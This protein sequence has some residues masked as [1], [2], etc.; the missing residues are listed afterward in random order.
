MI[1][2]TLKYSWQRPTLPQGFP[3]STIGARGLNFSVR[4]GKRCDP[5]A[6]VTRKNIKLN[7]EVWVIICFEKHRRNLL[8]TSLKI[9][10]ASRLISITRLNTLLR[11]HLWP[12]DLVVYKEPLGGLSHGISY[13]GVGFALR[14]FQRLSLPNIATQRCLWRDNWYTRDS[15]IPVLSY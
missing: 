12:I 8:K 13:L 4:K 5:S 9:D 15:S 2:G 11:L 7:T 6:I 10:Q 1:Q 14:C 3:S